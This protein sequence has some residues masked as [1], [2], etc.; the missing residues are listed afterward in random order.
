M[1]LSVVWTLLAFQTSHYSYAGLESDDDDMEWLSKRLIDKAD[2]P[3]FDDVHIGFDDFMQQANRLASEQQLVM[4][5][6][7]AAEYMGYGS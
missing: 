1:P 2:L 5:H 6:N 4:D 7:L 3:A